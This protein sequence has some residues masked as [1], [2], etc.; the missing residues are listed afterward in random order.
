MVR[1]RTPPTFKERVL[2]MLQF[3]KEKKD[4]LLPYSKASADLTEIAFVDITYFQKPEG[5]KLLEIMY[6]NSWAVNK[7]VNVRAN[8]LSYRGLKIVCKSDKAKKETNILLRKMHPTRPMLALQSSFRN[9]SI[10]TDVF[11]N[12]HD[13]LLFTPAG[14]KEKPANP[15]NATDMIG[16]TP[17]HPINIDFK[18][19]QTGEKIAFENNVPKGWTYR[20]DP[21]SVDYFDLP[22]DRVAHLKYNVIGDE[23]LGM[24]T[25]EPIYKT[26]ERLMK[27]EEG[28]T[29]GILTHGNPLHDII[30]GDESHIPTKKMIDNVSEEVKGL[31]TMSE[32]VHPPRIRV[33]QIEEYSLGKATNYMQPFIT[34]IAAATQVPEFILLGRGEGT[35]KAT[36]Q[37]MMNF[38]HQTIEP[39]QQ[40]QALYFEEQ[41][42]AP[43]M[44]LKKID[45]VPMIE[46]N[47]I[48]P[49]T[50]VELASAI[51]TLS[52]TFINKKCVITYEEARELLNLGKDVSFKKPAGTELAEKKVMPGIYLTEPHGKFI[53]EGKKK[54]IVKSKK[55]TAYLMQPIYLVSDNKIY[56]IIKLRAPKEIDLEKFDDLH[57]KHLITEK[58]REKWCG[59][60]EKLF[61]YEFNVLEKFKEPKPYKVEKGVQTFIKDVKL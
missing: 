42:L 54:L 40:A 48:L 13:E 41:I 4:A 51:N 12:A 30:V 19:D 8:L 45:E 11:G 24:S 28:I 33:V 27:I 23:L 61:A 58:E 21:T 35:N 50:P 25:I 5:K 20:L 3:S 18:R 6:R 43:L 49:S 9:R 38:I 7:A 56:G 53:W 32:Y 34:A 60:K 1:N 17:I 59:D 2:A 57:E 46:W 36:A 55:F 37:V 22:L 44:K 15:K 26:A 31:N 52:Q 14:T 16:F 47:E 29:Q 39:L 10:N